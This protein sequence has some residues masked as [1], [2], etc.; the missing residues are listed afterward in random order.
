[1]TH[2]IRIILLA[3]GTALAALASPGIAE[4]N[5]FKI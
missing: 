3:A 1:M 4:K 5:N 2:R